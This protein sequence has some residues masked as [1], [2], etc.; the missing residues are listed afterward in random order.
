MLNRTLS[1]SG[2]QRH[3]GHRDP[4]WRHFAPTRFGPERLKVT[5]GKNAVPPGLCRAPIVACFLM[6]VSSRVISGRRII[7]EHSHFASESGTA[8]ALAPANFWLEPLDFLHRALL[9]TTAVLC[10]LCCPCL[11]IYPISE[12]AHP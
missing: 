9:S 10:I 6:A 2:P 7:N 11:K 3:S 8:S 1:A 5:P 12:S 4:T